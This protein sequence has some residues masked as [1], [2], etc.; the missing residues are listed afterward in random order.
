M[1]K[2]GKQNLKSVKS[3]Q[4]TNTNTNNNNYYESMAYHKNDNKF[5]VNNKQSL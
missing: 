1:T 2:F 4:I 5:F 3:P